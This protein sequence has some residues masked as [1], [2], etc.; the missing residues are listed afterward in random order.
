M[1]THIVLLNPKPEIPSDEMQQVLAQVQALQQSIPG[2]VD[3]QTGENLSGNHQGYTYGFIMHFVDTEH[4]K[5][6]APHPAHRIVSDEI[7]R[8]SSKVIDFDV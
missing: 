7:R 6:Y 8:V 3:V 1:I 4:L 5:A 2:I